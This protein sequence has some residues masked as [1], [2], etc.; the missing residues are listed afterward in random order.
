MSMGGFNQLILIGKLITDPQLQYVEGG[1]ARCNLAMVCTEHYINENQ[2]AVEESNHFSLVFWN[3]EAERLHR[4]CRKGALI[5]TEGRLTSRKGNVE[6]WGN[7]FSL[8]KKE[9]ETQL[10]A[11]PEA[12]QTIGTFDAMNTLTKPAGKD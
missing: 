4:S 2:V 1:K 3:D 9:S 11:W 12:S 5:L 7:R 10:N 6:I 8:L